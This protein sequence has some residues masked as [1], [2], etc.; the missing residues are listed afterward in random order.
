MAKKNDLTPLE[1]KIVVPAFRYLTS[2]KPPP[3]CI[4]E[5]LIFQLPLR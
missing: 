2:F 4:A 5:Q 1:Q 3:A